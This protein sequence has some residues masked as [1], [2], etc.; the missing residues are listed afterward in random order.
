M[1]L[2]AGAPIGR[3]VSSS[4]PSVAL[5]E[6]F[7]ISEQVCDYNYT[8]LEMQSRTTEKTGGTSGESD[9]FF[10]CGTASY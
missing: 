10:A 5:R 8:D 1:T 2:L 9:S 4:V 7:I 3:S 6:D